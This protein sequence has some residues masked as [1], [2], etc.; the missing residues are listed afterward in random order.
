[1]ED[2]IFTKI[3]KGEIPGHKIYEDDKAIVILDIHPQIEGHALVIPKQQIDHIWDLPD[4]LYVHLWK[5]AKKVQNRMQEVLNPPRVGI[6]VEGFGVPH[7]HIHVMPL[8]KI[9]DFKKPQ[10]L[11]SEPDHIAL[12]AMA[13][14]LRI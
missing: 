13:D 14:K 9:E 4:D 3:I 12:A 7:A 10:D 8:Y 6:A 5:V 1:M 2:S 11:E